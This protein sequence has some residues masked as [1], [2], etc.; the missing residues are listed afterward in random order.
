MDINARI[1][2]AGHRGLVGSALMR[3]LQ[4]DGARHVLTAPR[5][6]L[7]LRDQAAVNRWFDSNRPDYV[8]LTAGTVGG[9]VANSTRPAD[10]IY[11]NMMMTANVVHAAHLCGARKLLFLGSSCAYPRDSPQPMKEDYLL[12][13]PLE[14]TSEP[15]A[16]SKIAGIR[17][18]STALTSSP[19][20]RRRCMVRATTSIRRSRT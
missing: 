10:F 4:G 3:R 17:G 9:I 11:D 13:G 5:D 8:F 18:D 7:D 16:M 20:F 14:P 2:V 1:F 12:T 6:E 15:Y 19:R